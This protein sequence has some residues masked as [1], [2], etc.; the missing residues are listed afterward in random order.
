MVQILQKLKF[1]VKYCLRE[2]KNSNKIN[3]L[4]ET[5]LKVEVEMPI[6]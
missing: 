3:I 1:D 6:T 4:P 2:T 5:F